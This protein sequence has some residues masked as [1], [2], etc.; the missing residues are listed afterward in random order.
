M[1]TTS[2]WKSI[3]PEAVT[4]PQLTEDVEVDVAVI[5]G[6]ITGI[7]AALNLVKAGKKVA[8]LEARS[9]G[10]VTTSSSTGNLYVAVQPYYQNILAKFNEDIVAM[11]AQSRKLAI[12][13][14][15]SII[16]EKNINCN[17]ARRPWFLYTADEEKIS[18]LDKEVE[19]IKKTGVAIGYTR[20]LSLPLKFK[21]AAVMENQARFNPMQYVIALADDLHKKG[22]LIFE[23]TRVIA[24]EEKN[25]CVFYTAHGKVIAKNGVIATHTPTGINPIQLFTAPYRSYAVAVHLKN[26]IYPEGHFWDLDHPHHATCTHSVYGDLPEILVVAGNHHKTGQEHNA[27]SHFKELELFLA[28]HFEV[29][30]VAYRWSA[31][32]YH[33][34]DDIPYI[35]LAHRSKHIYLATGFFADGL[36]Y[37]TLAGMIIGDLILEKDNPWMRVYNTG[38]FTPVASAPFVLKENLNVFEQY[39]KDCP[40]LTTKSYEDVKPDEAKVVEINGEKCGVYR[41]NNNRVHIVS[42]VCTHMKC[43]VKWNN[44]EKTWDCPCHGS[45]FSVEGKVIEGPAQHDLKKK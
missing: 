43:I 15:E 40:F 3:T 41:D 17:F 1:D 29:D 39:I 31:Q 12:D 13:C 7:T 44:A 27:R 9:I 14:I 10:G 30:D 21:K 36:I 2:L 5:G 32:H 20:D 34:A 25:A 11:I 24:M 19:T 45:R 18:F 38:R 4:Y 22:C 35:G 6:G 37:G 23:N 8:I 33:A 28:N 26:K 16:K 42:A